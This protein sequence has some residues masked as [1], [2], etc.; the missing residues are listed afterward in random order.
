MRKPVLLI[1]ALTA[2]LFVGV[3]EVRANPELLQES[4]AVCSS[5]S[6]K[7]CSRKKVEECTGWELVEVQIGTTTQIR[8]ECDTWVST[9]TIKYIRPS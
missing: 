2:S 5:G 3:Q 6:S 7:E 4:E 1:A 8:R 9:T